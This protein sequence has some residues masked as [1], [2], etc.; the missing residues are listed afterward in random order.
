[1]PEHDEAGCVSVREER[2]PE[3]FAAPV[4]YRTT[5]DAFAPATDHRI[6]QEARP[7]RPFEERGRPVPHLLP[8]YHGYPLPSF[9]R[10]GPHN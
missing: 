9:C 3:A 4:P 10:W 5:P 2:S 1:M 7:V 8:G 6:A